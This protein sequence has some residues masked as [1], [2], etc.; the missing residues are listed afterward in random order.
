MKNPEASAHSQEPN[1]EDLETVR[2]TSEDL[3]ARETG[4]AEAEHLKRDKFA[5]LAHATDT[6]ELYNL[7][8]EIGVIE[9][10]G[11]KFGA[12]DIIKRI[13][14]ARADVQFR[15]YNHDENPF[16][17]LLKIP[18]PDIRERVKYLIENNK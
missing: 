2:M 16:E 10:G 11:D 9:W 4:V 5:R 6:L 1:L 7:I 17:P 12:D 3:E 15:F 14:R 18:H 13:D 8:R